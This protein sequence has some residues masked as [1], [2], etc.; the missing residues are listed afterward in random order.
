M[1]DPYLAQ[2]DSLIQAKNLLNHPFY[3]AWTRGELSQECL[4][5]YAKEY[6]HHVKAFPRY[7]SAIHSRTEDT[8]TRKH[9][10][11]NL[12]EEEA[13][14]PNHPDLWK[15]FAQS[16]GASETEIEAHQP[17]KVMQN[18]I[19]TFMQTAQE[20]TPLEGVASLYA[21]E[22][23]IPAICISKIKG[24]QQHY[25]FTSAEQWKY[26]TVHIEADKEHAAI[27]RQ[28]LNQFIDKDNIVSV[29]KTVERALDALWGF[30]SSLCERYEICQTA[31]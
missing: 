18:L 30:L 5:E 21:Y 25:G 29:K 14:S 4:L 2:I 26:F 6:Y 20:K 17:S 13:G 15:S 19:Q 27:E 16:L 8:S 31:M 3:Q 1:S 10:L 22:S 23:Q 24:L 9:L 7:I 11:N 12:I 28:I